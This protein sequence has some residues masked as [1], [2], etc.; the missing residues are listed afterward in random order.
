[1]KSIPL[2]I[3][4]FVGIFLS[5]LAG[6]HNA[7]DSALASA[8]ALMDSDPTKAQSILDAIKVDS[9]DLERKMLHALLKE[10]A[11]IKQHWDIESDSMAEVVMRYYEGRKDSLEVLSKLYYGMA[12]RQHGKYEEAMVPLIFAYDLADKFNYHKNAGLSA[13]EL[14]YVNKRLFIYEEQLRWAKLEKEHYNRGGFKLHEAWADLDMIEGLVNNGRFDEGLKIIYKLDSIHPDDNPTFLSRLR[15]YRPWIAYLQDNP[16][17][18]LRLYEKAIKEGSHIGSNVWYII[19]KNYIQLGD[20][21]KGV[22]TI[23]KVRSTASSTLDSIWALDLEAH[24]AEANNNYR[25]A[26]EK[27]LEFGI[28]MMVDGDRRINHQ[29]TGTLIESL[30]S[31]YIL[32]QEVSSSERREKMFIIIVALLL[33]IIFTAILLWVL[34]LLRAKR[35]EKEMAEMK[36]DMLNKEVDSLNEKADL[37]EREVTEKIQALLKERMIPLNRLCEAWFRN[38]EGKVHNKGALIKELE[39]LRSDDSIAELERVID[40]YSHDWMKRF[41]AIYPGLT[42][43]QYR[44]VMYVFSGF[45]NEAIAILMEKSINALYGVKSR[46]K[47]KLAGNDTPEAKAFMIRLGL[48]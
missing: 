1:M 22:L 7:T 40:E 32:E 6:C 17:E 20:L 27:A 18:S 5:M 38:P 13:R 35:K 45:S 37:K 11:V 24:I 43:D 30:R 19:G 16:Q 36:V 29:A 33:A 39:N 14:S 10:K 3:Y 44:F 34:S 28:G 12:L 2:K 9:T 31:N 26:Y 21:E 8:D 41:R 47:E 23:E 25:E 46:L 4:I 42:K 48:C 15:L